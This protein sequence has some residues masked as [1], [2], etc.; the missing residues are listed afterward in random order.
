MATHIQTQPAAT[1]PAHDEHAGHHGD[2][3]QYLK[4]L[5]GLLALTFFTVFVARHPFENNTINVVIALAV[6]TVKVSL[7]ALYFMHL[8]HDN[9]MNSVILVSSF[10]FLALLIGTCITDVSSREHILPANYRAPGGQ[11]GGN[12]TAAAPNGGQQNNGAPAATLSNGVQQTI[13]PPPDKIRPSDNAASA[14]GAVQSGVASSGAMGNLP[15]E[16]PVGRTD[17]S[18]GPSGVTPAP[19]QEKQAEAQRKT[20][21]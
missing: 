20:N 8:R 15:V 16:N 18:P 10:V 1:H 6:A 11:P 2:P 7:V 9:P 13:D 5:L 17:I 19:I 4:I 14:L 21:H 12:N 3:K